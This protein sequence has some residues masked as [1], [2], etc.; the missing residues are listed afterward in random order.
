MTEEAIDKEVLMISEL[1]KTVC[2]RCRGNEDVQITEILPLYTVGGT[3]YQVRILN[4]KMICK[5][6]LTDDEVNNTDHTLAW[7]VKNNGTTFMDP[8]IPREKRTGFRV[9]CHKCGSSVELRKSGSDWG[10]P[11]RISIEGE[12]GGS[13]HFRCECGEDY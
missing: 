6:C 13:V 12:D 3:K 1:N 5:P 7:Y 11:G 8:E 2:E 4:P 10:S 9:T